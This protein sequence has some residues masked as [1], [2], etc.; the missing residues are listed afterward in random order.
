MALADLS[1]DAA[2]NLS[3]QGE[4]LVRAAEVLGSRDPFRRVGQQKNLEVSFTPVTTEQDTAGRQ[5]ALSQDV[6]ITAEFQQTSDLEL[7][8]IFGLTDNLIDVLV[9]ASFE[10]VE[11]IA[12]VDP[13]TRDDDT[14]NSDY[15]TLLDEVSQHGILAF[16]TLARAESALNFEGEES[17]IILTTSFRVSTA[18]NPTTSQ[19]G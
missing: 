15:S 1:V 16:S 2:N 17:N 10:K 7:D 5:K 9:P 18:K 8:E 11:R 14:S 6:E 4:M 3:R 19:V 13:Q 12:D